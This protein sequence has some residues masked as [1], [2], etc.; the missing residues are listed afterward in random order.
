VREADS[1]SF[2]RFLSDERIERGWQADADSTVGWGNGE[3]V[4]S[5]DQH[6][7]AHLYSS[8]VNNRWR[9][10]GHELSDSGDFGAVSAERTRA[11]VGARYDYNRQEAWAELGYDAGTNRM[12]GDVGA[13]LSLG[14]SWKLWAEADSDSFDV[15]IR[16]VTGNLH[17][18]SLD[19][20]LAWRGSELQSAHTGLQ[21]VLFSDGNQR[22]AFSGAWERRVWT[23]PRLQIN[24][25]MDGAESANSLNENRPYFNPQR[26]L[27]IGPEGSL[28]WL[29]WKRYDRDI[30][31]E[32]E[33]STAPYWQENYGVG[34][35]F[36]LHYGQRWK[37]RSG[38]EWRGGVTWTSQPYDG[39]NE[40][41]TAVNTGIT[42]GSQ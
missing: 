40:Y 11:G 26:D 7:E 29:T 3:E 27:S 12:A 28:D 2:K 13:K 5:N 42:W 32:F 10:Y 30:H 34:G 6:S 37:L 23:T 8:L 20:D 4:G 39:A 9:M 18:R 35:A 24:V 14:D 41:R 22:A 1:P 16:A 19:A 33:V 31:Q 21:R 38:L 36:S 17:G 25:S 15:P